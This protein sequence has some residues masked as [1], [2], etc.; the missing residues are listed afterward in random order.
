VGAE[1]V[2]LFDRLWIG[3]AALQPLE[4]TIAPASLDLVLCLDVLEHG[5]SL[6]D[7]EAVQ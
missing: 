4:E 3:D 7:G 2:P 6:V 1:A 5:G